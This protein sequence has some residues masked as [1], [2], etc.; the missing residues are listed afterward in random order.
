[1]N[2]KVTGCEDCPFRNHDYD[3]WAVG[4][5]TLELCMLKQHIDP[6]SSDYFIDVY[7]S[8][9]QDRELV[10]PEWCPLKG[11]GFTISLDK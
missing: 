9:D 1:M 5:D 3:D 2:I 11:D 10:T 8:R 6:S 4:S 7:S